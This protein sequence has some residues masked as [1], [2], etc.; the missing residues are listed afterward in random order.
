M[1]GV[2]VAAG[3]GVDANVLAFFGRE[4]CQDFV[5]Q[6]DEGVE[7]ISAS[8]GVTGIS[9]GSKTSCIGSGQSPEA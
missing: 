7:E 4:L 3:T 5:V 6:I 2:A 1:N 8:P 9:F